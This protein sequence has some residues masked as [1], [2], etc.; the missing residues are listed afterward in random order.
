MDEYDYTPSR[1]EK[2]LITVTYAAALGTPSPHQGYTPP[3][4]LKVFLNTIPTLV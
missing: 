1:P 2:M 3:P 4:H